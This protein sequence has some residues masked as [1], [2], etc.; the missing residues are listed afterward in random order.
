M[1]SMVSDIKEWRTGLTERSS[2]PKALQDRG[3]AL[4]WKD[5]GNVI[6]DKYVVTAGRGRGL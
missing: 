3:G 6:K 4:Q 2:D 1:T 5:N